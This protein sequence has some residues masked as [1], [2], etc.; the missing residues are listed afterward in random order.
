MPGGFIVRVWQ[1]GP[2]LWMASEATTGLG[3]NAESR[4]AALKLF[5]QVWNGRAFFVV[6]DGQPPPQRRDAEPGSEQALTEIP[7]HGA[8]A[9]YR[10]LMRKFHPDNNPGATFTA[11]EVAAALNSLWDAMR[12][13]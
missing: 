9:V 1:N 2:R 3:A 7:E 11:D 10:R 4:E 6:R 8:A 13:Q 12:S 5:G